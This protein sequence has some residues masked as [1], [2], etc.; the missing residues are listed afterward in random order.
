MIGFSNDT[1]I[2]SRHHPHTLVSTYRNSWRCDI[3]KKSY[4]DTNSFYCNQCDFDLCKNCQR[5]EIINRNRN[6]GNNSSSLGNFLNLNSALNEIFSNISN[7]D[8]GSSLI[9]DISNGLNNLVNKN[10]RNN[11]N[12]VPPV[13]LEKVHPHPLS[14]NSY[15]GNFPCNICNKHFNQGGEN[16]YFCHNCHFILC[17]SCYEKL[18]RDTI[19]Q[20]ELHNHPLKI[21]SR[22]NGWLCNNCREHYNTNDTS[23]YCA[24]CDYDLCIYCSVSPN[25]RQN[26]QR[27]NIGILPVIPPNFAHGNNNNDNDVQQ[28]N[29]DPQK[30]QKILEMLPE[31]ILKDSNKLPKDKN[32]CIICMADFEAGDC[33]LTLPCIHFY[34]KECICDWFNKDFKCPICKFDLSTYNG[35][36]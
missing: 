19:Y 1:E 32:N 20:P 10:N 5:E 16:I 31:E 15:S 29:I 25:N 22:Q 36:E 21:I 35:S 34:H 13:R 17:L 8:L 26:I 11:N 18:K 24:Q 14:L 2:S 9:R 6:S 7:L 33:V 23:Y 12:N 3:C 27:H 30:K 28:V 4:R